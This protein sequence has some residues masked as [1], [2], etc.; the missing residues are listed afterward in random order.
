VILED[1]AFKDRFYSAK[2][3]YSGQ[4]TSELAQAEYA[5]V[6]ELS[7]DSQTTLGLSRKVTANH[8]SGN[9]R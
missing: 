2:T 4:Y 7:S 9:R 1:L 3:D 6:M 8:D 5:R